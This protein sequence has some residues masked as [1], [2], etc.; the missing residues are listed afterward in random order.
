MTQN[1]DTPV[2]GRLED[3]SAVEVLCELASHHATGALTVTDGRKRWV[4]YLDD[5][6]VVMTQ[7]NL[8]GEQLKALKETAP[9]ADARELVQLQVTL[10][11]LAA[12]DLRE[13]EWTFEH[14]EPPSKRRPA[15]LLSACLQAVQRRFSPEEIVDRLTPYLGSF[16]DL[17]RGGLQLS[18]LP[19][20]PDALDFLSQLDAQRTLGDVL[21]FAPMAADEARRAV[22]FG[23]MVGVVD[24]VQSASTSSVREIQGG[25]VS[26]DEQDLISEMVAS[27][28]SSPPGASSPYYTPPPEPDYDEPA[29]DPA[30]AAAVDPLADIGA[31]I[32]QEIG[33]PAPPPPPQ[34]V[35]K[36]AAAPMDPEMKTLRAEM[37][38]VNA[39]R[40]EF[41]VLGVAWDATD[42]VYRQAYFK[43]ARDLHPDRWAT[44]SEAHRDLADQIFARVS[45]A[46][47]KLGEP[48][49]RKAYIDRVVHG[50]KSE[51]EL[52]ME[53][54]QQ[55]FAAENDFKAGMQ[56]F[57]AGR[58]SQAAEVFHRCAELVPEEKIYGAYW[59]F[60]TF[61]MNHG[62]N[63]E[64]AQGGIDVIKAAI[65]Q[66]SKLDAGWALLGQAYR[67]M[68]EED[69]ARRCLV[70]ALRLNPSNPDAYR[71]MKRL[72][73]QKEKEKKTRTGGWFSN[74]FNKKK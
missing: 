34:A 35:I 51:D 67:L 48:E 31:F 12:T 58:F 38:R 61:R 44:K 64:A 5:G 15:D 52:A 43:L 8:R 13:G 42:D 62:K 29:S 16:P 66:G 69:M 21:D 7:S 19:L 71:E 60:C 65:D 25:G 53:K 11:V 41:E 70:Q 6:Q 28:L 32:A 54:V 39:A 50:V 30:A 47:E 63:E 49:D 59:G 37:A 2:E 18:E 45:A 26:D 9:E 72:Q 20:T 46:W 73:A 3:R 36:A 24:F 1:P 40:D 74:L 22:L 10:R 27:T 56:H 23:V 33:E 57:N 68:G 55:I 4:F 17:R 14:S